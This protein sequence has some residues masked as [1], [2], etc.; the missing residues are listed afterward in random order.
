MAKIPKKP[1]EIFPEITDD[2][3][4]TF[5]DDLLSIFLYGSGAGGDYVPG[6]SDLNFLMILSEE[7]IDDLGR[8]ITTV[9]RWRK[10]KVAVPLLM[11]KS[12]ITSSLDSYP[13]EF[14]NIK[15]NHVLVFG[16]D[17]LG[18]LSIDSHHLRLQVERELKGKLLLLRI[19][20]LETEGRV[21]RVRH[22]IGVSLPAFISIFNALLYLKD[23]EIPQGKREVIRAVDK[24]FPIDPEVFLKCTD[25]EEGLGNFSSSDIQAI[26]RT[27]IREI[28]KLAEI[29]DG[30]KI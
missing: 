29:I 2:F 17:V 14:L 10:R 25:I 4:K 27:Y 3:R 30:M 24:A 28:R 16:E 11:T 23:I 6:K 8:A 13:L 20:F 18:E 1:E 5:G 15:R 7:G 22:L 9:T 12:Y 21:K 26:F 19:G